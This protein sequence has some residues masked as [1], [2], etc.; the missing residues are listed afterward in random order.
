MKVNAQVLSIPP[1]ISC[2]WSQVSSLCVE[3]PAGQKRLVIY[4]QNGSRVEIP[5]LSP[6]LI[7][8]VFTAH[9][10]FLDQTPPTKIEPHEAKHSPI[11]NEFSMNLMPMPGGMNTFVD[12]MQHTPE[13]KDMPDVPKEILS[14][15]ISVIRTLAPDELKHMPKAEPH[16]NCFHCQLSRKAVSVIEDESE[17]IDGPVSDDELSFR[18]WD[19]KAETEDVFTVSNPLDPA[20]SYRVHL[21]DPIG[22]TC[23]QKKCE[24]IEAALRS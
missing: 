21:K 14:K 8:M 3:A 22:C 2:P 13:Q 12:M 5:D 7:D 15:V 1:Y 23:G 6:T 20:E 11:P 18:T 16:C 4:M 19:V 24:H 17:E 10:E 9:G